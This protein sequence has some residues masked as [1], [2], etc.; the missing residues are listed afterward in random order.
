[1][2]SLLYVQLRYSAAMPSSAVSRELFC[3]ARFLR[4]FVEILSDG[5]PIQPQML[6]ELGVRSLDDRLPVERAY[7]LLSSAIESTRDR[8]LGLRAGARMDTGDIGVVDYLMLTSPTVADA[9]DAALRYFVLLNESLTCRLEIDDT[10]AAL[11]VDWCIEPPSA[12]EDFAVSSLYSAHPWLR[13]IPGLECWFRQPLPDD[14]E[15]YRKVFG[16][17]PCKFAADYTGFVFPRQELQA[18]LSGADKKL[19]AVVRELADILLAQG[20]NGSASFADSVRAIVAHEVS[21]RVLSCTTVARR[22]HTSARTLARK[23]EAEGTTFYAIVD[24]AR[25][26]R[27][28]ELM[29]SGDHSLVEIARA[30]G[31]AHLASFHRAFR[32]WTGHTPAE[33]R[34]QL[35]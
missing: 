20:G 2:H 31:F 16:D 19:H 21:S 11:R 27:A 5:K 4:P 26:L 24:E 17:V 3:S 33:Y 28:L 7:E 35:Q 1:M 10:R 32:R 29:R 12:A 22:L 18:P 23:L 13:E 9:L 6:R 8:S 15:P 14:L 34:I 25:K 30:T